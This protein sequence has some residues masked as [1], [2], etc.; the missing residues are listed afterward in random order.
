M[1]SSSYRIA[2]WLPSTIQCLPALVAFA[3]A[4][5]KVSTNYP[6]LASRVTPG[7][8]RESEDDEIIT[9]T[10]T[11]QHPVFFVYDSLSRETGL[12]PELESVLPVFSNKSPH[13]T[14]LKPQ[15]HI[16][17][18]NYTLVAVKAPD[19]D[20]VPHL[21][22]VVANHML[23]KTGVYAVLKENCPRFPYHNTLGKKSDV[24][25]N[26]RYILPPDL[27]EM[28]D[29]VAWSGRVVTTEYWIMYA[30]FGYGIPVD[31]IHYGNYRNKYGRE[32]WLE[33]ENHGYVNFDR[34]D[35]ERIDLS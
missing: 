22:S 3:K 35:L 27:G 4:G 2:S 19:G 32:F 16:T 34:P 28:L 29:A 8:N 33:A 10:P 1:A 26:E 6:T 7:L 11:T 31:F 18:G 14:L 13:H 23:H 25:G 30:A 12:S 15:Y 20:R 21:Q 24:P 5:I 17:P 9:V